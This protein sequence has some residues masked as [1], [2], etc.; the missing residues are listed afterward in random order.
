MAYSAPYIDETG[1][2]VP[3]YDDIRDQLINK[4]KGIYGQDI[5]LENDSQDYQM[6]SAFALMLYDT[7]NL[8][9]AIYN[10]RGPQ[11]AV[12][13]GLDGVIKLNG[14]QRKAASYSTCPLTISGTVGTRIEHGIAQDE[15]GERWLLP[16]EVIITSG[17][18]VEVSATAEKIG[19]ITALPNTI[20]GIVTPTKGWLSVTNQYAAVVGEP[21]ETNAELRSRQTISTMLV[22]KTPLD[23]TNG[24]ILNVTNVTRA[25][26]YENDT[27]AVDSNTLP[28][29]SICAVVE[30]G[31]DE[32]IA[33]AIFIR[34]TPGCYT[35][36]DTEV[37]V[38]DDA[39]VSNIIRFF[40]PIYKYIDVAISVRP[41]EGYTSAKTTEIE[42]FVDAY[43]TKLSIGEDVLISSIYGAALKA[44]GS[45][46]KPIYA[47][48]SVT[49]AYD[50]E[51]LAA[52]DLPIAFNEVSE[53]GTITVTEVE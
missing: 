27:N 49:C 51:T 18:E 12:G 41:L 53:T 11:T 4:F 26:L 8:L 15:N 52:N 29:H 30:G 16:A 21:V 40:R 28:P 2:H 25:R 17:G 43:L 22:A 24:A 38:V 13:S 10:N 44:V 19:A 35:Y 39:G 37:N 50:G 46:D 6:I 14:I 23:G 5:Y 47:V 45:L 1:L 48:V 32:D 3:A 31:S 34:K 33:E 20:T 7:N 36:G 42:D 9:V